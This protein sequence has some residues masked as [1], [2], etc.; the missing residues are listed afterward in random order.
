MERPFV[1]EPMRICVDLSVHSLLMNRK[2][3]NLT[4]WWCVDCVFVCVLYRDET[5]VN[6]WICDLDGNPITVPWCGRLRNQQRTCCVE[7]NDLTF[8]L[9]LWQCP[10]S[11]SCVSLPFCMLYPF[12]VWFFRLRSYPVSSSINWNHGILNGCFIDQWDLCLCCCTSLH[13]IVL[14]GLK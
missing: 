7:W 2:F 1:S 14:R 11:D 9:W 12:D 13:G 6:V 3:P 10:W 5:E 4:D 8:M